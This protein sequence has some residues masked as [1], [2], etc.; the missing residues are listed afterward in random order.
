M[1]FKDQSL[2]QIIAEIKSGKT[3]EKE[4]YEYFL[5]RIKSLD[6][7]LQAFNFVN[8]TF[9]EKDIHSPLA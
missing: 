9:E 2:K 5:N 4:V 1:E 8:E 7:E 3:T 6:P